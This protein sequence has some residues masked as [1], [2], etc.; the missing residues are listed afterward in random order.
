PR[1][2]GRPFHGGRPRPWEEGPLRGGRLLRGGIDHSV[3]GH[4]SVEGGPLRGGTSVER[5]PRPWRYPTSVEDITLWAD[6][7]VTDT[8]PWRKT[9]RWGG[10]DFVA[11][12]HSV[13]ETDLWG[14]D[15]S[16]QVGSTATLV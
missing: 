4:H 9:A 10:T 12:D 11:E 2:G 6:N 5:R 7:A 8:T 16:V 15:H 13:N 14:K 1:R 3:E